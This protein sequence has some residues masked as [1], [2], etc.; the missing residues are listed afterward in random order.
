MFNTKF[1]KILKYIISI[2]KLN[3]YKH[4][5]NNGL[6]D[7]DKTIY[8]KTIKLFYVKYCIENTKQAYTNISQYSY[9]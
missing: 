5:K 1:F 7:M 9:K 4:K 8:I 6:I 2:S 3:K